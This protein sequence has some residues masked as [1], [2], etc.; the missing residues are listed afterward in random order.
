MARVQPPMCGCTS[1]R[2]NER[3]DTVPVEPQLMARN[4]P[5]TT[6]RRA[7]RRGA[8]ASWGQGQQQRHRERCDPDGAVFTDLGVAHSEEV[9]AMVDVRADRI[10]NN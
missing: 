4:S 9:H 6:P 8:P 1:R 7:N 10:D 2:D 3:A 5:T